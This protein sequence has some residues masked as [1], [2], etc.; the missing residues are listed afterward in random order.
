MSG[1]SSMVLSGFPDC[2]GSYSNPLTVTNDFIFLTLRSRC[3]RLDASLLSDRLATVSTLHQFQSRGDRMS[4]RR[5]LL[6]V[7][8]VGGLAA[9]VTLA[10]VGAGDIT[11]VLDDPSTVDI[12]E[13]EPLT[14]TARASVCNPQTRGQPSS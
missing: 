4:R 7:A 9:G 5:L 3:E 6:S 13:E 11:N 10:A 14:V 2:L 8:I 12:D 1:L